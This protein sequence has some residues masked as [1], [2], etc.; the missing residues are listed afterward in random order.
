MG[1]GEEDDM[2]GEEVSEDEG[3]PMENSEDSQDED[4][5]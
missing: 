3:D 4:G 5:L 2:D 1:E